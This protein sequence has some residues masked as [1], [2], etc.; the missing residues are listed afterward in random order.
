MRY[1]DL[2]TN[3]VGDLDGE[4]IYRDTQELKKAAYKLR[5]AVLIE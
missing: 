5:E 1:L 2:V 4:I 3:G